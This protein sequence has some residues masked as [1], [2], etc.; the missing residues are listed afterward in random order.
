MGV[1]ISAH[2]FLD[3]LPEILDQMKTVG[4]LIAPRCALPRCLGI[5]PAAISTND[6][7]RRTFLQPTDT[8]LRAPVNPAD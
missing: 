6:L 2:M 7:D 1:T 5:E 4:H 8:N 3:C